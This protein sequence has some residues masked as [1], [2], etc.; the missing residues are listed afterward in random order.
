MAGTFTPDKYIRRCN[1]I[2]NYV[3]TRTLPGPQSRFLS[4]QAAISQFQILI[5]IFPLTQKEKSTLKHRLH[6]KNCAYVRLI[7]INVAITR[8]HRLLCP[9]TREM[10]QFHNSLVKSWQ[11]VTFLIIAF[12]C[13]TYVFMIWFAMSSDRDN[14]HPILTRLVPAGP[15]TCQTSTAF[16]CWD[17]LSCI[18]IRKNQSSHY[19]LGGE[20]NNTNN[21]NDDNWIYKYGRDDRKLSLTKDQCDSSFPGLFQDV[22]RGVEYWRKRGGVTMEDIDASPFKNGMVRAMILDGELYIV[23]AR[24]RSEDHRRKFLATLA[25]MYRAL[26][27]SPDRTSTNIEFIFSVEDRVDDVNAAGHPVWVFSRK[28]S[29]ESVWLMPDFGLWSWAH[30]NH[31]KILDIGPFGQAVDRILAIESAVP[32]LEKAKKLIWRGKLSFSPKLRHTLLDTARD[33]PWSDVKEINWDK[34]NM[35]YVPMED[36]CRYMFIGHVEGM[37]C[38]CIFVPCIGT[39]C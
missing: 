29:E 15:C 39:N 22:R 23:A 32:F 36:H 4:C 12:L 11:L 19:S 34:G 10:R 13:C 1:C 38:I 37:S 17:C 30:Y 2:H 28:A 6:P 7:I 3:I 27:A 31:G 24:A 16:Q 9:L 21:S 25:A 26:S 35:N 18:D 14:V 8:R 20:D 33:K 5:F